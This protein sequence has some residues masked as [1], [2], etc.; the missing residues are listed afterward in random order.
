M[1]LKHLIINNFKNISSADITFSTNINGL[2]GNNGM[3][4]SNLLDA[5]YY[6]SFCRSFNGM[7]DRQLITNGESFMMLHAQYDRAGTEE[8]IQFG[9][10]PGRKKSLKRKGK[11]YS[12]LSQHIGLFPLVLIAPQDINLITG[13][14]EDRRLFIDRIIS[15]SDKIYLENL[16]KYNQLLEH[17]NKLLRDRQTN[18][19]LYEAI[20]MQMQIA[21]NYIAKARLAFV[22]KFAPIF[23]KYYNSITDSTEKVSLKYVTTLLDTENTLL[24]QFESCRRKDEA[25]CH[26]TVGIHRDDIDMQLND[27]PV[28]RVASQGQCKS[29]VI[30]MRLAQYDFLRQSTNLHPLLLLDDIFDKLDSTRVERIIDL[31]AGDKFGQIFITDTNRSHLDSIMQHIDSDYKIWDVKN[32]QFNLISQ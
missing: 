29:Y 17:R 3:G 1:I 21:A 16:I 31:V 7:L 18:A 9:F 30:S 25:V 4:K 24:K 15:Q 22:E 10:T 32:G 13:T 6:L 14:S 26:T 5:I 20:E 23:N 11:E 28:K 27:M 2:I 12:K 8:D 19:V